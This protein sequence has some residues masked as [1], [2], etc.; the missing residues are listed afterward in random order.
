MTDIKSKSH[1]EF[2]R[3]HNAKLKGSLG[4]ETPLY[5]SKIKLQRVKKKSVDIDFDMRE[6]Y[7]LCQITKVEKHDFLGSK[8]SQ[9]NLQD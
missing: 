5:D 4:S 2:L 3:A 6:M 8:E 7:E 1:F 9:V